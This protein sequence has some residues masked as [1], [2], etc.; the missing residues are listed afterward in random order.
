MISACFWLPKGKFGLCWEKLPRRRS[1]RAE[2]WLKM[3]VGGATNIAKCAVLPR[4]GGNLRA[5]EGAGV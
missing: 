1:E 2:K 5:V 4:K 3:S